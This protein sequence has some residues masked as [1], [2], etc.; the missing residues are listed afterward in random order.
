M[1]LNALEIVNTN[2]YRT[3]NG[4]TVN[5]SSVLNESY[6]ILPK[7]NENVKQYCTVAVIACFLLHNKSYI[8]CCIGH[9]PVT[10]CIAIHIFTTI[11]RFCISKSQRHLGF[12]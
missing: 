5:I 6:N 2:P 3:C 1:A 9:N 7:C 8:D 10:R 4:R 11:S 12:S